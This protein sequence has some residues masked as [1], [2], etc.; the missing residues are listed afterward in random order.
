MVIDRQ[1][2]K[3]PPRTLHRVQGVRW[4]DA[5]RTHPGRDVRRLRQHHRAHPTPL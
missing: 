2:K 3:A 1:E 4:A 5:P